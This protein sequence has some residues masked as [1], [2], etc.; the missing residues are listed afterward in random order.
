VTPL[1]P[2]DWHAPIIAGIVGAYARPSPGESYV[3]IGV[4]R[5]HTLAHVAQRAAGLFPRCVD[6]TLDN[7]DP[8]PH[9]VRGCE[10]HLHETASVEFFESMRAADS[11]RTWCSSTA[12]TRTRP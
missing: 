4:D 12:I 7:L 11:R 9:A 8:T 5:G 10:R 6:V 2:H 1:P 3:E